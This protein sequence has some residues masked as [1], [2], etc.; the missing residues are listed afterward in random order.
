MRQSHLFTKTRKEAPSDEVSKNAQLLIR[1]GYIHKEMAGV[2]SYL[3]L[4]LRVFNNVANII[5]EEMDSI[6]GQ[7]LKLTALQDKSLWEKT[8]RWDDRKVDNWF[9]T[10]LKNDTEVGLG[11]T[12]EEQLTNLM[13]DYVRSYKDLPL[14]AYQIQ[15]KFRNEKRS[16]SGLMRGREF[17]MKD[18]YSFARTKEEHEKLYKDVKEAYIRIFK[19]VGLGEVTKVTFASGGVFSKYSEEFQTLSESGEDVIYL[20]EKKGIAVNQEV[21]NDEVLSDLGLDKESLVEK[22]SIETGNIF[23]LGTKFSEP[24]GL[25]FKDDKENDSPVIM[26]SY[27]IGVGRVMGT[28]V[29]VLSDEKGIVWPESVAPFK[30]HLIVVGDDEKVK[31]HA[32]DAYETLKG[33]GVKVLLDD[34]DVRAGEKFGDADLMGIPTRAVISEKT[35]AEGKVEVTNRLSGKTT[36]VDEAEFLNP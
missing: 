6:G 5:R 22:K 21:N 24:L 2:Y 18:M 26:G 30:V 35:M 8:D 4:G 7:E 20:D 34:R 33:R 13:K 19:R 1:A 12:H 10:K 15:T 32:I 23:S 31:A 11:F 17:S 27:G 28:L 16:K 36:M 14:L 29:E 3:P 25:V 9:K